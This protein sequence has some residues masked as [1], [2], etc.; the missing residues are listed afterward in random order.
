MV[1]VFLWQT[2]PNLTGGVTLSSGLHQIAI[3]YYQ[4]G[5]G[6][7]LYSFYNGPDTGNVQELIPN[8][9]LTPTCTWR[10]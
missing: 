3:A 7:S 8:S 2:F 9:V 5:G 6:W 4:Q 1:M 10:R